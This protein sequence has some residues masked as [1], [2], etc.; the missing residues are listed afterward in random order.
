MSRVVTEAGVWE[1]TVSESTENLLTSPVI[2]AK[3]FLQPLIE[4]ALTRDSTS[5]LYVNPPP[6]E[7]ASMFV[8]NMAAHGVFLQYRV[9]LGPDAGYAEPMAWKIFVE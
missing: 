7:R 5:G 8:R 4:L 2:N 3:G 6:D 1:Y 9:L